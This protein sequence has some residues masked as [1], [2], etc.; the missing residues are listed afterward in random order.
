MPVVPGLYSL[1]D[2]S[3]GQ[4]RAFLADDGKEP[5][6]RGPSWLRPTRSPNR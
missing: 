3:G 6:T 1:G 5:F 4:V 2:N